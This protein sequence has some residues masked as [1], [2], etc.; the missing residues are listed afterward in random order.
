MLGDMGSER[1]R[2]GDAQ[3]FAAAVAL[4]AALA[5]ARPLRADSNAHFWLAT[6]NVGP[7]VPV[8]YALPG[9]A[10]NFQVRARPGADR[11]LMAF[12]LDLEATTPDV[13]SF[14]EVVV[15]NPLLQP[16]SEMP[17]LYRHQLV[18]DSETGLFVTPT[19]ID[20]FLGYSFFDDAMGL[21]DG[22]GMGPQ[23]GIDPQCSLTSGAPSWEVATIDYMA[24]MSYGSTEL[25]LAIGEHGLWQTLPGANPAEEPD[26]TS[27]IFGLANDTV[28]QWDVDHM[29]ETPDNDIDHRHM[30][31]GLADAVI[32]VASA[33]FD[34]DGDVDGADLLAWQRGLGVGTTHAEGDADGNGVVD[35]DDLAAWRFQFGAV[36]AALPAGSAAPEPSSVVAASVAIGL[37]TVRRRR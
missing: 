35:E 30:P 26:E 21:D 1:L 19:L 16:K 32:R 7:V 9:S 31:Q 20:S 36:D 13:I 6:A 4:L 17:A 27:A 25:Y 34:E 22:A 24:S 3:C 2:G 28:N 29:A 5:T 12:S 23:C 18:F 15:L 37:A 14:T 8:I 10:G 11:R 33:D